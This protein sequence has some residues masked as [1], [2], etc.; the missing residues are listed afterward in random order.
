MCNLVLRLVMR[1]IDCGGACVELFMRGDVM[2]WWYCGQVPAAGYVSL[3][4]AG[5]VFIPGLYPP[6]RLYHIGIAYLVGPL[7]ALPNSVGCGLTDWWVGGWVGG[8]AVVVGR[9]GGGGGAVGRQTGWL[10]GRS[11]G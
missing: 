7:A 9:W 3:A 10:V 11:V 4:A 5:M 8:T 6:M 1:A 2:M